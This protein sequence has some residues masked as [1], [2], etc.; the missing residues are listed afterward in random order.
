MNGK[1]ILQFAMMA[2]MMIAA[3]QNGMAQRVK[4]SGTILGSD[5]NALPNSY[6]NLTRPNLQ[7]PLTSVKADESGNFLVTTDEQGLLVLEFNGPNHSTYTAA[8]VVDDTLTTSIAVRLEPRKYVTSIDSIGVIGEFNGYNYHEAAPLEKMEDGCY[9]ADIPATSGSFSYQLVGLLNDRSIENPCAEKFALAPNDGFVSVAE[10]VDGKARVIFDP[11]QI[12]RSTKK[13]S[14]V[15][16]DPRIEQISS[17][18]RA[19]L[20]HREVYN[21]A[22]TENRIAGK[23]LSLFSYN[24]TRELDGLT[25]MLAKEK[26]SVVRGMLLISYLEL[27][28]LGAV[29]Q[30]RP[31]MVKWSLATIPPVSPLWSINPRLITLAIEKSGTEDSTYQD[32]LIQAIDGQSDPNISALLLYDGLTVAYSAKDDEKSRAYYDRLTNQ[33][34]SSRYAAM[35]RVQFTI[36][37]ADTQ[38]TSLH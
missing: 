36:A 5:G 25:K 1:T 35:A 15:Y 31:V 38:K 28:Q 14:A 16:D 17:I 9:M 30:M 34:S 19:I 20:D 13:S 27:G 32:Y 6:V 29:K 12:G 3:A 21:Q 11:E 18:Y 22:L 23:S 4:I 37:R 33:F 2:G 7:H 8:A 10:V 24:W 26:D